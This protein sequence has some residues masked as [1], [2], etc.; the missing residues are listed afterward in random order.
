MDENSL[1]TA[2]ADLGSL[3]ASDT[4]EILG[5]SR[6]KVLL[7]IEQG[8]VRPCNV[9]EVGRG[10]PRR[11]DLDGLQMMHIAV[12][13]ELLGYTPKYMK[14]IL[15]LIES[16]GLWQSDQL[17]EIYSDRSGGFSVVEES[18]QYGAT[19]TLNI[20]LMAIELLFLVNTYRRKRESDK[21]QPLS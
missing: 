13:L 4:S 11:L 16:E 1:E 15:D 5:I 3:V 18:R 14:P 10:R 6:R 2:L 7:F 17:F 20:R 12:E 8:L 19:M 9:E 21:V